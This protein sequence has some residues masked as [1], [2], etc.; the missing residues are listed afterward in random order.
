MSPMPGLIDTHT[1]H[2]ESAAEFVVNTSPL[3]ATC[4][5][6]LESLLYCNDKS[7]IAILQQWFLYDRM[8]FM[9]FMDALNPKKSM[10]LKLYET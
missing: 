5:G 6:V 8:T 7:Y 9:L 1:E 10:N 4:L 2:R 3:M